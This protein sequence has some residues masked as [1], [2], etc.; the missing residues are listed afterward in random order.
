LYF[1]GENQ[2]VLEWANRVKIAAGAAR[3]LTYLHED[4][5]DQSLFCFSLSWIARKFLKSSQILIFFVTWINGIN[6]HV[7]D[8]SN[9]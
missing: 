7:A 3:G 4:C 6:F 2:P 5:N 9:A 1:A 8:S